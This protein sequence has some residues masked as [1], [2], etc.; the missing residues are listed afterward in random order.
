MSECPVKDCSIS[1]A[2]AALR[3]GDLIPLSFA[4]FSVAL[5]V[6]VSIFG[7]YVCLQMFERATLIESIK[8]KLVFMMASAVCLGGFAIWAMHFIGMAALNTITPVTFNVGISVGSLFLGIFSCFMG[9]VIKGI[10]HQDHRIEYK[11]P[12]W[13]IRHLAGSAF[14]TVGV[15]G[16]H[17]VGMY[18]IDGKVA[19]V[20]DLALVA[21]SVVVCLVAAIAGLFLLYYTKDKLRRFACPP[22]I[23]A[24]VCSMHYTGVVGYRMKYDSNGYVDPTGISTD[25]MGETTA[26]F[27]V[28]ACSV[29]LIVLESLERQRR[30]LMG[31]IVKFR[32]RQLVSEKER[33]DIILYNMLPH[34]VADSLK[35]G[36]HFK[37]ERFEHCCFIFSDIVG[38]TRMSSKCTPD[39]V[40]SLLNELFTYY[41]AIVQHYGGFKYETVGDC[42]VSCMFDNHN[43]LK[44]A[45]T[46]L[47]VALMA[48]EIPLHIDTAKISSDGVRFRCGLHIGAIVAGVIGNDRPKYNFA[49]D[50]I[51]TASRMESTARN[52]C[53]QISDTMYDLVKDDAMFVFTKQNGIEVKGKGSMITYYVESQDGALLDPKILADYKEQLAEK[54]RKLEKLQLESKEMSDSMASIESADESN[55]N[56]MQRYF[57]RLGSSATQ[58]TPKKEKESKA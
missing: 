51:N 11:S 37:P 44:C 22:I 50:T 10:P 47:K 18:S 16:M 27:V 26:V 42:Y 57:S 36:E 8:M 3:D 49:G 33:G 34:H 53:T 52:G 40:I 1:D 17:Y 41:D 25:G 54:D 12:L 39:I 31:N 35:N 14:I 20:P 15:C 21:V 5:S 32:T 19:H 2:E 48:H 6:F 24:A 29:F 7:A 56:M 45:K 55:G 28:L 4:P 38:F 43:P 46:M 9:L 30:M 58:V 23:A 13:Y